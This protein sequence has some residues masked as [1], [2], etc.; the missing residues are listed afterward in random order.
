MTKKRELAWQVTVRLADGSALFYAERTSRTGQ[1]EWTP[2]V[3]QAHTFATEEEAAAF[4][5]SCSTNTNARE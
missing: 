4:A 3:N 2:W 5:R 1:S